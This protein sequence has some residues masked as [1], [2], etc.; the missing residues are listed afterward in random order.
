VTRAS[1]KEGEDRVARGSPQEGPIRSLLVIHQGALGDFIL[2]LPVLEALREAFPGARSVLMGYPRILELAR[3]RVYGD[4]IVSVD[5]AGMGSFFIRD[6]ELDPGL[7]RFLSGFDLLVV[8]GRERPGVFLGNL[9]RVARGR[10]CHLQ[11]FPAWGQTVHVTDHLIAELARNGI[12]PAGTVPRI[13]LAPAD[14]VRGRAWLSRAG[15]GERE[16]AIFLHPGSGSR[17]KVWPL[18]RLTAVGR[19]LEKRAGA[20]IL[21]I[22]G[23]AEGA[24]ARTVF[25]EAGFRSPVFVKG[26]SIPDLA[27]VLAEGCLLVGNDSGVSHLAASLGLPTVAVFGPTDPRLWAPRSERAVVVRRP[28]PCSPC[29]QERLIQ[30]HHVDCLRG[31]AVGDVLD[32]IQSLAGNGDK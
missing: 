31:V 15:V 10:I 23:P 24:E 5:Q 32:A 3:G 22:L 16:K 11:S 19:V 20:R 13:V 8:F 21:V 9:E 17:R 7:S 26:L 28:I 29:P 2:A 27:S 14:R 18:E 25:E 4:D 30:C 6:G 1:S 12:P